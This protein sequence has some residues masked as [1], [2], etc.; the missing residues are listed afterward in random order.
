MTQKE[1]LVRK[2]GTLL[3]ELLDWPIAMIEEI[4]QLMKSY[5]HKSDEQA[6]EDYVTKLLDI[7]QNATNKEAAMEAIR[8]M[9]SGE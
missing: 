9:P 4:S 6:F 1:S 7:V 3:K 8:N 2:R 5:P